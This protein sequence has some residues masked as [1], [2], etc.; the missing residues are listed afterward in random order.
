MNRVNAY[1]GTVLP[2]S[3]DPILTLE[4]LD[5]PFRCAAMSGATWNERR[6][7]RL[8][9][10]CPEVLGLTSFSFLSLAP[11]EPL[12]L[13][14]AVS[15]VLPA[16]QAVVPGHLGV[17][18]HGPIQG[19]ADLP[20][21]AMS[22]VA[23]LTFANSMVFSTIVVSLVIAW[24]IAWAWL[25]WTARNEPAVSGLPLAFVM[26][27]GIGA[28]SIVTTTFGD[29]I[30]NAERYNWLGAL[31]MLGA[32]LLLPLVLWQLTRDLLRAR[33]ALACLFGIALL[34]AGW[35]LWTRN[36]PLAVGNVERIAQQQ[37]RVL[38][39][40]G[41]ALDPWGVK[42][43]YATVGGG[44]RAEGTRGIERRD[45][46]ALYPGYPEAVSGGFRITIPSN[47]WRE[48]ETLRVFVENRLGA[49]TEIDRRTIV[50]KP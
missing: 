10:L 18:A 31:A 44:P 24:P 17:A 43:V 33:I 8:E 39:V 28:Y 1:L 9:R 37:G 13:V 19:I 46:Q 47:A 16:A 26:L 42:R 48:N 36:Q 40:N 34:A 5:L 4:R 35:L 32:V 15:R 3:P 27:L 49:V 21:R 6:G 2:A 29:G 50:P 30:V 41:W 23:L 14:R 38:E 12:T 11:L 45:V 20:P 25:A 7:E 22:F